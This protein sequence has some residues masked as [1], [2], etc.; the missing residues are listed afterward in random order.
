MPAPDYPFLKVEKDTW[1]SAGT[2]PQDRSLSVFNDIILR[3]SRNTHRRV[4]RRFRSI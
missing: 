1:R 2:N 4:P 3:G